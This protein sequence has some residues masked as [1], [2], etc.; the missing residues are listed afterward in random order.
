ML[1][2]RQRQYKD[3]K[4]NPLERLDSGKE[5]ENPLMISVTY[6]R[7]KLLAQRCSVTVFKYYVYLSKTSATV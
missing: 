7:T 1:R 3:I 4:N 2:K 6:G 5:V